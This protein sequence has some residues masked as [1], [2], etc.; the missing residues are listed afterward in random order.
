MRLSR[1]T[2]SVLLAFSIGLLTTGHFI[3]SR[4]THGEPEAHAHHVAHVVLQSLYLLPVIGAAI[5][6]GVQ[7]GVAAAAGVALAYSLHFLHIWP[8]EHLEY[9]SQS[10][11]VVMFFIVGAIAG[12]LVDQ[13]NRERERGLEI[14][15]RAQRAAIV[16]GIA[17]LSSALGVRDNYTRQHSERVADLAVAVGRKL[18]MDP[19]RVELLRLA[20]LVHDIGKIGIG[21]DILFKPDELTADERAK[22]ERH[23]SVAAEMLASISGTGDIAKIVLAHHESPDGR[24]YPRG[25]TASAIPPEA[26]ALRVADVFAALTDKRAYKPAMDPDAALASMLPLRD[27]KFDGRSLDALQEVLRSSAPTLPAENPR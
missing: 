25:L 22:I 10:A 14:E 1:P 11:M 6:F 19:D 20:A 4:M 21:D 2:K 3:V 5:W 18:G 24:G 15:R 7:G 23:P 26:A 8:D 17:G 13:Q 27:V 16:Q 9:V 12:A